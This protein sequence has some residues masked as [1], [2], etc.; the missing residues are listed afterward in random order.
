MAEGR[1]HRVAHLRHQLCDWYF[2]QPQI[3]K[4]KIRPREPPGCRSRLLSVR[5]IGRA[6]EGELHDD[7]IGPEGAR[8][9]A[10]RKF[11]KAKAAV[12]R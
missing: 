4:I 3:G 7:S 9:L 8:V 10:G 1:A 5:K 2:G 12:G 6:A 11:S